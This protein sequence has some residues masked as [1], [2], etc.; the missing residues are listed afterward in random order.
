[1]DHQTQERWMEGL[2]AKELPK[3]DKFS[4]FLDLRFRMMENLAGSSQ[5]V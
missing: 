1:M 3:W 4:K 5:G 2:P